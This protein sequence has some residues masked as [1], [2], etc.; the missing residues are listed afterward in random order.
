MPDKDL[1]LRAGAIKPAGFSTSG[2]FM[3]ML[4][5]LASH[6]SFDLDTPIGELDKK[7][8]EVIL[9]GS[10]EKIDWRFDSSS[11]EMYWEWTGKWEGLIPRL[12]RLYKQTSSDSRRFELEKYMINKPCGACDGSRLKQESLAV[13]INEKNI[14][15]LNSL[16]IRDLFDFISHLHLSVNATKIAEP[17]IKE[18][19]DRLQFLMNVGL[20]YLTL[21]RN[22][23]TLSGG[24][25]QRI[26]LATQIGSELRG[27]MYILDEPSIGL[28]QRDNQ[29]LIKTLQEMRDLGNTVIV[30]EHDEE[31][32]LAADHLIDIGPGAGVHGGQV[33]AIG[34]PEEVKK[35]TKSLTGDYLAHRQTISV[36]KTRRK[37]SGWINLLAAAENNLKKINVKFPTE[38]LCVV[39]G[40]SGSGKSTLVSQTLYP[41]LANKL[42]QTKIKPGQYDKIENYGHVD[43]VIIIDQTPIGRTPRSNPATYTGVFTP[44][45]ELFASLKESKIKGYKSGRFSF[46]V[47][48]GRCGTCAG[49]GVIKI[50]MNFLPDVYV[51]CENCRGQRYNEETLLIRYKD[52]NIADILAMTIEEALK[53]FQSIPL[54][55]NKLQIMFDVGLGY[56]KLGQSATTLSGGEAQR[57]KLSVELAK[58]DTG[59]TL[60]ILDEPTTGLHFADIKKMLVVLNKLVDKGNTILVI[61]HNL[62]V[63]KS[64]DWIIDLGPEGGA[65][66]GEVIAVGTPEEIA[67]KKESYTGQF[68]KKILKI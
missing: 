4:T 65:A 20:D 54:I 27:V 34:T 30:V 36:P 38:V 7:A 23:G 6:F 42:Y 1:S 63:I 19:K 50:E 28:H 5:R 62:D 33:M 9:F 17:I 15:E 40:V 31:T 53:F 68:L 14:F 60:Y 51:E 55:R 46:N 12:E 2:F 3:K 26:R 37:P 21:S 24:E 8:M 43:K 35:N 52:K 10:E 44:I 39:T 58:R 48:G 16:S 61:E 25:A 56:I 11:S 57:L 41:I 29:K 13:R 66:G 45:R 22:G 64:A 18:T 32:M 47:D 59:R 49:D 67:K